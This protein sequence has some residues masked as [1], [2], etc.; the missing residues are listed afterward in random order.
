MAQPPANLVS[1]GSPRP[2]DRLRS[3]E[4]PPD[5]PAALT[6]DEALQALRESEERLSLA[7]SAAQIGLWDWRIPSNETAFNDQYYDLYGLPPGSPHG[8]AD[9]LALVHPEDRARVD[10]AMQAAL[11]GEGS[12]AADYRIVRAND[13]AV[14]WVSARGQVTFTDGR[15]ARAMG[16]VYDITERKEAEASVQ[17]SGEFVR[18][19]LDSLPALVVVLDRDG[20]VT[21]AN[22]PWQRLVRESGADP[23]A[24]SIGANYLDVCRRAAK[25]GDRFAQA[26]LDALEAVRSGQRREAALEYPCPT[27]DREQWFQMDVRRL[28]ADGGGMVVSHLDITERKQAEAVLERTRDQLAEGQRIAHLG[29]WEYLAATRATVW[30]DEQKRIYG[31]D[32]AQPSPDYATMLR[33]HIH[34]DD[35]PELDRCFRTAL[36]NRAPFANENRIVRPDGTVRWIYNQAQPYFDNH[37]H[38]LRYVGATLDIT[39]RKQ[40]ED[41]L[42]ES[43]QQLERALEAGQLGFWDWDVPSGRM[44]L[45]GQWAAMLGYD[46]FEIEPQVQ[47]WEQLIHP[48]EKASVKAILSNHLEGRT[49]FYECEHRMRHKDGSWRWIL[50]RGQVVA[51]D[52]EGRAVRAIGTHTDVTARREAEDALREADRRKDEFL[53]TLAHELRNPLA[54]IRTALQVFRKTVASNPTTDRL[55]AMMDRQMTHLVRLV[56]DLLEVS[57]ITRGKIELRKERIA[58]GT[59]IQHALETSRPLIE[60]R[61]HGLEVSLPPEP[62]PVE[63][64]SV[65]LTQVFANLLNN[66]AKYTEPGGT[67]RVGVARHGDEVEVSIRDSGVG[68]APDLLPRVFDLFTQAD[69]SLERSQ[70][71]LGIGLALVRHLVAMHGGTVTARSEGPGRGSE[72]VVRLP[73]FVEPS[74]VQA[75]SD[76]TDSPTAVTPRRILII[77]DNRD[78]AESLGE[79][80][81]LIGHE[82]RL[83]HD[84]ETGLQVVE[85]FRPELV[86]L[87]LGMPRMDGFETCRQLRAQP[88]GR[89]IH[90]VA[91]SGWG[92]DE[93]RRKTRAAGF[94]AHLVKPVDVD[95]LMALIAGVPDDRGQPPAGSN[96]ETQP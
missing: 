90:I 5:N 95:A 23:A 25:A 47:A 94:D 9:F 75:L 33:Q 1:P 4:E 86:L 60:A 37:G 29:S 44:Q 10:A 68:I 93:D 70:G 96:R 85:D 42:L 77:D 16:V 41:A 48:D 88:W 72:F 84:G 49:H 15:P 34:P 51:R 58:L 8:Y 92:Q 87:D 65:R 7:Q 3:S 54:P 79:L 19:V 22:E 30:S 76:P 38:L 82:T 55:L 11:A 43:R 66:A 53:A 56:D 24:V 26:A 6:G 63:A 32:P 64:D 39:E 35:A 61:H 62:L 27:P 91:L 20:V 31:L 45:G 71:G 80:L 50:D 21:T 89:G 57:R 81:T 17:R 78:A 40:A 12:Y 46:P 67:L 28:H 59:V 13:G 2:S 83:A 74:T 52:A 18:S 73:M 14:R 69:L 36:E